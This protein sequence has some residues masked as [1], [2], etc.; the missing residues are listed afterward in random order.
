MK[1]NKETLQQQIDA[2]KI[3][4][5]IVSDVIVQQ[6]KSLFPIKIGPLTF[7]SK[8]VS[9][10]PSITVAACH[11][12]WSQTWRWVLS[13][14]ITHE[15]VPVNWDFKC[16][17]THVWCIHIITPFVRLDFQTQQNMKK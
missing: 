12:D 7:F 13:M 9:R 17:V 4:L 2:L 6:F 10:T 11:W 16:H 3:Q 1:D 14:S 8:C 15:D 5:K